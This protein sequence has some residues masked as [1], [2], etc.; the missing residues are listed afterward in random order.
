VLPE[1]PVE[2]VRGGRVAVAL[3]GSLVRIRNQHQ[4][5]G[6]GE[7]QGAQ[8]DGIDDAEDR[9]VGAHADR[10][11]QDGQQQEAW[12]STERARRVSEILRKPLNHVLRDVRCLTPYICLNASTGGMREARRAGK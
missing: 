1:A 12:R 3:S 2:E 7:R 9:G 10:D 6:L 4:I 11:R 5:V 8:Q